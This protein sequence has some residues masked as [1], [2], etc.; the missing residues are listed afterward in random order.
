MR[1]IHDQTTIDI[2]GADTLDVGVLPA[3][4]DGILLIDASGQ[5]TAMNVTAKA[6]LARDDPDQPF[7][8]IWPEDVRPALEN[9]VSR[10]FAGRITQYWS[11]YEHPDGSVSEWD[12]RLSPLHNAR[13]QVRALVAV[14]RRLP[15]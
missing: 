15:A 6:A 5:V 9:A 7:W 1:I 13:D 4:E 10:G 2:L 14:A 11:R 8:T 3:L 12:I